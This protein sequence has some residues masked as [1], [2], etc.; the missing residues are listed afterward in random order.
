MNQELLNKLL[1]GDT[2]KPPQEPT[3]EEPRALF[4]QAWPWALAPALI[5]FVTLLIIRTD[6]FTLLSV[7]GSIFAVGAAMAFIL[8]YSEK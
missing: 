4:R 8:A 7:T 5:V 6:V 2:A 1:N 3:A